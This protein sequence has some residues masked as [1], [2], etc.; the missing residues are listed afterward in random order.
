MAF[1]PENVYFCEKNIMIEYTGIYHHS[2]IVKDINQSL[3][4]YCNILGLLI[5][6]SRPDMSFKGAWL[7]MGEQSIHLLQVENPDSG[8]IRPKHGGRDR[9]VAIGIKNIQPLITRLEEHHIEFS[10]S[11]SGRAALF[12]R[13][14]DDNAIE[15]IQEKLA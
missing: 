3:D 12:V 7:C 14:I 10:M 11:K 15:V 9:H 5:D 13:D 6:D 2:V 1:E 4:F 8:A